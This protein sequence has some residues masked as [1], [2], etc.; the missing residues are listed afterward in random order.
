ML[1]NENNVSQAPLIPFQV[2]S[3]SWL[4][5]A[6]LLTVSILG[7]YGLG[8]Y[9]QSENA[10]SK[11]I[12]P[13]DYKVEAAAYPRYHAIRDFQPPDLTANPHN[14][15][16]FRM[17]PI[18]QS[19]VWEVRYRVGDELWLYSREY[20]EITCRIKKCHQSLLG[21]L[22]SSL[23]LVSIVADNGRVLPG[24]RGVRDPKQVMLRGDRIIPLE[25]DPRFDLDWGKEPLF[26]PIPTI[27]RELKELKN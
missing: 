13:E 3:V 9:R 22:G 10:S 1:N 27:K 12:D 11:Y 24:W 26:E 5:S 21:G 6:L 25:F 17:P 7:C 14:E 4:I 16:R 23:T 2:G 20:H 18:L 19:Y 8:D 15:Q